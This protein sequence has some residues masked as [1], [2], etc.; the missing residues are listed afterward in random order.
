MSARALEEEL[1]VARN[2]DHSTVERHA[3]EGSQETEAVLEARK[4]QAEHLEAEREGLVAAR[5][6]VFPSCSSVDNLPSKAYIDE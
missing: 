3:E 4:I 2:L 1:A 5:L 6:R